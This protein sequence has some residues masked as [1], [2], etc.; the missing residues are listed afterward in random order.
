MDNR[1]FSDPGPA[2][3]K[4]EYK[5][6]I[7][8]FILIIIIAAAAVL[9]IYILLGNS[10]FSGNEDTTIVYTIEMLVR[11]EHLPNIRRMVSGTEMI[12]SV[13]NHE[14][15]E[16]LEVI[17]EE[18][19]ENE[20]DMI[21]GVVNRVHYPD[22]S[23]VRIKVKA[24]AVIEEGFK[25]VING[26]TIMVGIPVDFRTSYFMGHGMCVYLEE[27]DEKTGDEEPESINTNGNENGNG[28]ED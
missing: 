6:N 19:F 3:R 12:D 11:N 25:Y 8:D 4:K 20:T 9:L 16:V 1:N 15:G 13:R 14:I 17:I 21:T 23:R 24:E 26:K 22:H 7:I 5:F 18:A 27:T 10:V 28:E 2:K